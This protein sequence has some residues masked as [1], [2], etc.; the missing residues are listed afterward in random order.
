MVSTKE[1]KRELSQRAERVTQPQFLNERV[2]PLVGLDSDEAGRWESR[3]IQLDGTGACTVELKLDGEQVAF[4]KLFPDDSGPAMYAKLQE[5]RSAG[6]G[7][8]QHYQSVEP[9]GFIAEY[10]MLLTRPALGPAVADH[11]GTNNVALTEGAMKAGKWLAKLHTLPIRI[12]AAK[13]LLES[14]ELLP[15]ARRIA[16]T[17]HR[18]SE[19]LALLLEMIGE[20]EKLAEESVEGLMVQSHGQYRPIH[21]FVNDSTVMVIDLDRSRPCDPARDIAEFLHRL[22]MTTFWR[23]GSVEGANA[24]TEAFLSAYISMVPGKSYLTNLRFHWAR[25]VFHSLNNKLKKQDSAERDLDHTI[26]FYRSE[27]ENVINGCFGLSA[28]DIARAN[29]SSH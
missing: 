2:R 11:I 22:R 23:M 10:D 12:G 20:L 29:G 17:V 18:R 5:L 8:K 15:L 6:F 1:V 14:G 9:L 27:F 16:K 28:F 13:P 4:G 7:A 24:P 19:S 3:V 26:A 25:Y 21:V